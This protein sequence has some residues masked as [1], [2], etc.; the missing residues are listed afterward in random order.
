M[1]MQGMLIIT[2][3]I[4]AQDSHFLLTIDNATHQTY[5]ERAY[6]NTGSRMRVDRQFG[7]CVRA[8]ALHR[9]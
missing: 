8:L 6:A 1:V 4:P 3:V 5:I 7:L 2:I 9:R